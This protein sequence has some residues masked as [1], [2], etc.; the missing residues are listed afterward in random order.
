MSVKSISPLQIG[1]HVPRTNGWLIVNPD[2]QELLALHHLATPQDVLSL[3]GVVV[4]GHVGRNVSRV[5]LGGMTAYLKREH[6]VQF[7]SRWKNFLAGFGFVSMSEREARVLRFLE[8][9]E[10]CGP[11]WMAYGEWGGQAFLLVREAGTEDHRAE[12]SEEASRAPLRKRWG[13]LSDSRNNPHRLR[14]G[15]LEFS[16]DSRALA[17]AIARLHQAGVDQ[18]DLYAKHILADATGNIT[19]LDW[20]QARL[21]K[22]TMPI[23]RVRSLAALCATTPDEI[24]RTNRFRFLKAY[25][26]ECG[27]REWKPLARQIL[28]EATK[29]R[30]RPGI[31]RQ[32]GQQADAKQLL[33]RIQGET[34]CAV[35]A[36]ADDL[37]ND[38]IIRQLHDATRTAL[39][40][41]LPAG[42]CWK[43][44]E[45]RRP[46]GRCWAA[47]RG[48]SW[49]S[50]E[51]K[52][53]R[54]VM[55]LE[56]Y[57]VPAPK[58]VAYGQRT[59][60]MNATA[61]V[62]YEGSPTGD[63][64]MTLPELVRKLHAVGVALR[65]LPVSA[66]PFAII[67]G[68]A[69]VNDPACF[70]LVKKLSW[71]HVERANR[72]LGAAAG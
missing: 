31:R 1:S 35:P 30:K 72:W 66:K 52:L 29:L 67:D 10:L 61:F 48:K 38:V 51:L 25:L 15:A 19:I 62:A 47:L 9:R 16:G 44:N 4:N 8:E 53:A 45:Y 39:P 42:T 50:D 40:A 34:V 22:A 55:H 17:I 7:R 49:R 69:V 58:I 71:R 23:Q 36:I 63:I 5:E 68:R 18:P 43:A 26:A 13:W 27:Q 37:R 59:T 70:E 3:P 6:Q 41:M 64:V 65:E 14:S 12:L 46:W 32:L 33:V 21:L 24:G 57:G 54:L 28:A 20:Q 2:Y 60:G 56:R 11:E